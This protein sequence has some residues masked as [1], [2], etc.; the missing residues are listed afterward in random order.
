MKTTKKLVPIVSVLI[1]ST[2]LLSW[3]YLSNSKTELHFSKYPY[4][5]NDFYELTDDDISAYIA[6]KGNYDLPGIEETPTAEDVL[7]QKIPG[8]NK[9]LLIMAF[10]SKE[11]YS[12][13]FIILESGATIVFRDDGKGY[14][15]KAGDGFYTARIAED[16]NK[17]RAQVVDMIQQMKKNNY[18]PTRFLRRAMIYDPDA[19]ESFDVQKFD[20]NEAVSISGLTNALSSG[21]TFSSDTPEAANASDASNSG[22]NISNATTK[23]STLDKIRRNSI[24]ITNL[25]VVED[26]TRTWNPCAQ[27]GNLTGP[28]TFGTLMRQLASKNPNAIA[29]DNQVSTFVLNWL[30]TWMTDQIVNGDTSAA[31]I[32]VN[33]EIT[34]PWLSKSLANGSPPGQLDMRFA[35]F[36]LIAITN[37][38]DLRNGKANGIK[39]SP[40][41]EG[42]FVFGLINTDCDT[43]ARMTVIF[44]YGINKPGTC[45]GRK[46]WAQQWANLKSLSLGSSQYNQALQNITDQFTLCGTDS[47]KPNF[48]SLDR[49]RTNEAQLSPSPI[50][51]ELREFLLSSDGNLVQTTVAQNPAD[52]YNAQ[53]V[54]ADVQ[55]M[56]D[57]VNQ[58]KKS[59]NA[60]KHIVPVTWEGFPFLG[61]SAHVIGNPTGE[62]PAVFHWDGT[63]STNL[64]TY[65]ADNTS[66]FSFSEN[67][68]NGCHSGETQ[69]S[70]TH[71][72]PVFF[73]KEAT[74]SGFLTG[75]AGIGDA[76]DFDNNP[77][78]DSMAVKDAGLRPTGNPAI[79]ILNDILRR[80]QDLQIAIQTKC[81]TTF[82]ISAELM[83]HP[84]NSVH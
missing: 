18:H 62:P 52:K 27:K 15:E 63:D 84:L 11:N 57:F 51:W 25:K 26:S 1:L 28:W 9:H 29:N 60:G 14:D 4:Q 68:C 41:G 37:R 48:S 33:T 64:S 76:I 19:S 42:R 79:R 24:F 45:E 44:E 32:K 30:N 22:V 80:A 82:N 69:T 17:F 72:N 73:G 43:S 12:K 47:S 54:N 53:V 16:V 74:L 35:P 21:L 46:A 59:I 55:R 20:R 58:N 23:L 39:G 38:F 10:Y 31:R 71:V 67:T 81:G 40:C 78:N 66:R 34:S 83:F 13:P 5:N 6:E 77:D 36:K 75:K 2:V 50:R 7:V 56:V 3:R 8:D 70:F 65:I 49:I 61:A